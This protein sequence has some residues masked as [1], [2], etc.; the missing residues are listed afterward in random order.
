MTAVA[1]ERRSPKVEATYPTGPNNLDYIS[2]R[3]HFF[4]RKT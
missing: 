4:F 3:R 1:G 2:T